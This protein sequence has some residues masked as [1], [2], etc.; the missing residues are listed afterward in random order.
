[1][2][3]AGLFALVM[4]LAT[5]VIGFITV[6][7]FGGLLYV[8]YM[9]I[10]NMIRL[11]VPSVE[12]VQPFGSHLPQVLASLRHLPNSSHQS[13]VRAMHSPSSSNNFN[14]HVHMHNSK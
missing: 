12:P 5:I 14:S 9:Q 10:D 1:M 7:F 3:A 11:Q 4:C 2:L 8:T 6:G 13:R